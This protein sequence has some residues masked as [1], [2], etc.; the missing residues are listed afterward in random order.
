MSENMHRIDQ[1]HITIVETLM[2]TPSDTASIAK[3]TKTMSE[4][5]NVK[6]QCV[7]PRMQ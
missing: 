4:A 6:N 5:Q 2:V 3:I 1:T 7:L